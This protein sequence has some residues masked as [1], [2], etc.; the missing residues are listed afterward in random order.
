SMDDIK[1]NANVVLVKLN[2]KDLYFDPGAA[3]VPFGYLPWNETGVLGLCLSKDGSS[4]VTTTLLESTQAKIERQADLNL[5]DSGDLEGKVTVNYTGLEAQRRRVD[6]RDADETERKS[7][8]ENEIKGDVPAAIEIE[9]SNKP[10]WSS[11][12]PTLTAE[13][14]IKVPGWV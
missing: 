4:W 10:D 11:S 3:F 8:L 12:S 13:F 5:S 9:L 1:L 2:G 14:K 7:D 6:E